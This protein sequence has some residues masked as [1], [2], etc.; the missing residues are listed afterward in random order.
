MKEYQKVKER[1]T[2]DMVLLHLIEKHLNRYKSLS[3]KQYSKFVDM[4]IK[5]REVLTE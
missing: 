2:K 4:T 3:M 5:E 1:I